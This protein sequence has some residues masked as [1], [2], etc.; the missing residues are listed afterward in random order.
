MIDIHSHILPEVDDGSK[1]WEMSVHMLRMAAR[2]GIEH[3]VATPHADETYSYDRQWLSRLLDELRQRAGPNPGLSLGCDFHFSYENLEDLDANPSKY[4][5]GATPYLLVE[6]SDFSIPP[7]VTTKLEDLVAQDLRP[8]IT[9]PERNLILQRSPERVLQWADMGCAVQVTASALTGLWGGKAKQVANWLLKHEGI[10]IIATDAHSID[11]RPP[12]LSEG[13][14]AAAQVVGT[15]VARAL[16]DDNPRAVI[17]GRDL[18][19]FPTPE[20]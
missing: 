6:L 20:F 14:D 17:E 1:S 18:P 13:R 9:H 7:S 5:I 12:I 8:I 3:M 19:Y 4:T 15:D 2:D 10:H 16:V 11:G